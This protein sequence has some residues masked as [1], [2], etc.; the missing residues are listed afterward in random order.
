MRI[1]SLV[2]WLLVFVGWSAASGQEVKYVACDSSNTIQHAQL[3]S[4]DWKSA[5]TAKVVGTLNPKAIVVDFEDSVVKA[6]LDSAKADAERLD[7]LR[8]DLAGIGEFDNKSVIPLVTTLDQDQ[9]V[10]CLIGPKTLEVKLR[11]KTIPVTVVGG[12]RRFGRLTPSLWLFL[13]YAAEGNV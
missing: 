2:A 7:L 8:L 1:G 4:K 12:Y 13:S 11:D 10:E 3:C 5:K 6:A 9:I